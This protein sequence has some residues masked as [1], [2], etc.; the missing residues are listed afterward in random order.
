MEVKDKQT[1]FQG[2]ESISQTTNEQCKCSSK[3]ASGVGAANDIQVESAR[4][5]DQSE[6]NQ[7]ALDSSAEQKHQTTENPSRE[8]GA[9]QDKG[10]AS[11]PHATH[12]DNSHKERGIELKG[13]YRRLVM[14]A[15]VASVS[16]ALLL[17][18]MKFAV[19]LFSG[20]ATILASL[21]DSMIDLGASFINLL[22]LRYA[23]T[24]PDK[25]HR[26]GHYKAEALA[27]LSQAAFISGSAFLLI[28]NGYDRI[29]KPQPIGYIDIA[30][31]VS[32]ASIVLT[33]LL[34]LFQ[35][36][37][38]K[39]THSE[40]IAAD[41]FHYISDVG[42]NLTVILSLVL[43]K[44]GYEWADGVMAILLG[45]Y[46]LKSSWHI[47]R[48]AIGTLLD[49]SMSQEENNLIIETILNV[50]GVESFH[51]LR[52][53]KAG[54][55][56]Y[57]QCHL[58]LD[59]SLSLEQA[60]NIADEI[61]GRLLQLFGEV[62]IN[63]HMEPNDVKTY[64]TIN[65]LDHLSCPLPENFYVS[66]PVPDDFYSRKASE[67]KEKLSDM[68]YIREITLSRAAEAA[69]SAEV[70]AQAARAAAQ[71]ANEIATLV[72]DQD[73]LEKMVAERKAKEQASDKAREQASSNAKE[74]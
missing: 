55:Q 53:R 70:A 1:L 34:T 43:S 7:S 14:L 24:P 67:H 65:F 66:C 60:H 72:M 42:L 45:L 49:K 62:D 17:I 39:V 51:D 69:K 21:T 38:C 52:T 57:I 44:F 28:I 13:G 20:S 19:W 9:A 23:L 63:L 30:I 6:N 25:D 12:T 8:N 41:R 58:V 2:S 4:S 5:S 54:P 40:A 73:A 56:K 18:A 68:D 48:T 46:I 61:E 71:A 59:A 16:T 11:E 22:A 33:V 10:T 74:S 26:F 64:T 29:V 31:Y 36:Y 35:G 47:G 3:E 32:I 15:G 37:V 27:S 50:D